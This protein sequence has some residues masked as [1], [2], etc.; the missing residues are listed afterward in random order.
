MRKG[1]RED[2]CY[3]LR[4]AGSL[5]RFMNEGRENMVSL[6]KELTF[7]DSLLSPDTEKMISEMMLGKSS[8][9]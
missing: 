3:G 2:Q 9:K 4:G 6:G 1:Y 8:Q 5:S 7:M